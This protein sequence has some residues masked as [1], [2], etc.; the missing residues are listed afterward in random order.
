MPDVANARPM[1]EAQRCLSLGVTKAV[2]DSICMAD[3]AVILSDVEIPKTHGP[4][5]GALSLMTP[6]QRGLTLAIIQAERNGRGGEDLEI[7]SGQY[8][9]DSDG[10]AQLNL[11][12]A[13]LEDFGK[14]KETTMKNS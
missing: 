3:A 7:L 4:R 9:A 10:A 8:N 1:T 11:R 6:E 5:P 13:M 12:L 2:A 14:S